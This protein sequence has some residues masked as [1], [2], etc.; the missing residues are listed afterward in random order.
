MLVERYVVEK[1]TTTTNHNDSYKDCL[2]NQHVSEEERDSRSICV[3]NLVSSITENQLFNLFSSVGKVCKIT[4]PPK[5]FFLQHCND[6]VY[7][8]FDTVAAQ[9]NAIS[10]F[11]NSVL[12]GKRIFVVEKKVEVND[13]NNGLFGAFS[14]ENWRKIT[15]GKINKGYVSII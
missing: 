15:N 10:R 6:R 14:N 4:V 13:R 12:C 8:E 1:P 11:N 9:K 3:G 7:V 5:E 2:T